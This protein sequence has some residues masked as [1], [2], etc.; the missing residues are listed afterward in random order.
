MLIEDVND[1]MG[2]IIEHDKVDSIGG[3]LFKELEGSPAVGKTI[4]IDDILIEVAEAEPLRIMRVNI[5]KVIEQEPED[6]TNLDVDSD[7]NSKDFEPGV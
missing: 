3:W 2:V 4:Q 6:D 5:M 1:L 7:S